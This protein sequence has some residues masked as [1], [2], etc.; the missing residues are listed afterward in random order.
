MYFVLVLGLEWIEPIAPLWS[1]N[2]AVTFRS[3]L[4][5]II[6]EYKNYDYCYFDLKNS[7]ETVHQN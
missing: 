4:V 2:C 1:E 6:W 5:E 3:W 7:L